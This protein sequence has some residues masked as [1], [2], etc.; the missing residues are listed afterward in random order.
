MAWRGS[1]VVEP[2]TH[3]LKTIGSN[4]ATDNEREK[5]VKTVI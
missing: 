1:T 2:L 3:Y 5:V 4:L